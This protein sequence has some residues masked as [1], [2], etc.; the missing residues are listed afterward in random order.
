MTDASPAPRGGGMFSPFE[1][2]VALRYLRA[3]RA[4]GFVS[5]IVLFSFLGIVLGVATLIVVMSV[6]N[7]FHRELMD[8]ILGFN[9]HAFVQSAEPPFTDWPNVTKQLSSIPGVT[10]A[11]PLVEK[12]RGGLLAGQADGR[13][14]ARHSRGGPQAPAGR[15]RQCARWDLRRL[16][17]GGGPRDRLASRR[18]A[19]RRRRRQGEPHHRQGRADALRRDAA[20]QGLSGRRDLLDRHVGVRQPLP[21]YAASRGADFLQPREGG[22]GHRGL[23]R[24]PGQDRRFHLRRRQI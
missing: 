20:H 10:L 11:V 7:G 17:Q 3:R 22:H 24:Q 6:M 19:R 1:W 4:D 16:R 13:L 5:V 15:R 2:M 14:R 8:K 23:R 12:P 21:L 9:G 18:A